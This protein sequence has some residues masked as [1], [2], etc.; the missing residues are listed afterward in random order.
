M[1]GLRER[2]AEAIRDQRLSGHGDIRATADA[3]IAT[4]LEALQSD[5]AVEAAAKVLYT[6]DGN[7]GPWEEERP[8]YQGRYINYADDAI[9]AALTAIGYSARAEEE[10]LRPD[11]D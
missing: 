1:T 7:S 9:E 10:A 2:V 11:R 5:E 8:V 4:V 6:S 3:A